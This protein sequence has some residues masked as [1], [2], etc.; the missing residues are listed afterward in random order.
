MGPPFGGRGRHKGPTIVINGGFLYALQCDCDYILTIRPL[1]SICD[2]QIS[3][4]WVTVG[5]NFRMFPLEEKRSVMLE[6]AESE[7]P[8]L[9]N[10]E[11]NFE[12]FQP[13]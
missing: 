7:H 5:Q 11:I 9:T 8:M 2:A 12:G 3:R 10:P 1:F 4:G 13:M 6:F